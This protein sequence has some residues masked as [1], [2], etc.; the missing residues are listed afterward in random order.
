MSPPKK[1]KKRVVL[2]ILGRVFNVIFERVKNTISPKYC[3]VGNFMKNVCTM[4]KT[5][6]CEVVKFFDEHF[7]FFQG[8]KSTFLMKK[9]IFWKSSELWVKCTF[10]KIPKFSLKMTFFL[11]KKVKFSSRFFRKKNNFFSRFFEIF[12]NMYFT[13]GTADAPEGA[14]PHRY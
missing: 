2:L 3:T 8:K 12:N 5:E 4:G 13:G 6:H 11:E 1:D 7:T 14:A 10:S 9:K